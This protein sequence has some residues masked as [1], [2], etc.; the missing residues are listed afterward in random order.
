MTMSVP[1]EVY[2]RNV[3]CALNWISTFLFILFDACMCCIE[4]HLQ[5]EPKH[6]DK[7]ARTTFL[8]NYF[9]FDLANFMQFLLD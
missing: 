3:Q 9:L 1:G 8:K 2:S 5:S 7:L 6:F 4:C